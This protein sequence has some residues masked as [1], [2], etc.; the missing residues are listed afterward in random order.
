MT[1][2]R[3]EKLSNSRSAD[4]NQN[5]S[6]LT[7]QT[8]ANAVFTSETV[9][10]K[11]ESSGEMP[12]KQVEETYGDFMKHPV[13]LGTY[14]WTNTSPVTTGF[15]GDIMF[16]FTSGAPTPLKNKLMN[17]RYLKTKLKI[18]VMV[19]GCAYAQGCLLI[20]FDPKLPD[21]G[22]GQLGVTTGIGPVNWQPAQ[23]ARAMLLP[24]LKI[25]PSK[26]QRYEISLECPTQLGV[27]PLLNGNNTAGSYLVYITPLNTLGSGTSIAAKVNLMIYAMLDN[28]TF[29]TLTYTS[30][31]GSK[32]EGTKPS[33]YLSYIGDF[34]DF[35]TGLNIPVISQGT[36]LFTPIATSASRFLSWLGFSRHRELNTPG[37][38]LSKTVN[39]LTTFDGKIEGATLA[40][41][42]ENSLTVNPSEIPLCNFDDQIIS[43]LCSKYTYL[44]Q[45]Q[46]ATTVAADALIFYFPVHPSYAAQT[47]AP[48]ITGS[49]T[50]GVEP[51]PLC[52]L[53]NMF[54]YWRGDITY[55]FEIIASVFHR[56][57]LCFVYFPNISDN[58][59]TT[60]YVNATSTLKAWHVQVS[61]NTEV[62]IT[63]PWSQAD[64]MLITAP[65]QPAALY[66]T[67]PISSVLKPGM[68]GQIACYLCNP[69]ITN[70]STDG[71]WI[72]AYMKCDNIQ[73][74]FPALN[75]MTAAFTF[76]SDSLTSSLTQKYHSSFDPYLQG[77]VFGEPMPSSTKQLASRMNLYANPIETGTG[78][79]T[80]FIEWCYPASM[81]TYPPAIN[82]TSNGTSLVS[83]GLYSTYT[84]F[85]Y[86]AWMYLGHRGSFNYT[87]FPD[88][89]PATSP[90][91]S[92]SIFG[93]RLKYPRMLD[94][95]M[96]SIAYAYYNGLSSLYTDTNATALTIGY[97][98]IQSN[99]N[100]TVPYYYN[101]P[102]KMNFP[103]ESTIASDTSN[104]FTQSGFIIETSQNAPQSTHSPHGALFGGLGDDGMFV[105]FRG[106]PVVLVKVLA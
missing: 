13:M 59:A 89:V 106:V 37:A 79:T 10:S 78:R 45:C 96:N 47:D 28:P 12:V 64:P 81:T 90:L 23:K 31:V 33:Q 94:Q 8:Q 80:N 102:F 51:G 21:I 101:Y 67:F 76:T 68:N 52:Y 85:A 82:N 86:L 54:N 66:S 42:T 88:M 70:G 87:Y 77:R 40:A 91:N 99:I 22:T 19:Q 7:A 74:S 72:N 5:E 61:G 30:S 56:A 16:N 32:E 11:E 104:Q 3:P 57:M 9:Q 83:S 2:P 49:G 95:T 27:Y 58:V 48:A 34:S 17:F 38:Y 25:D 60:G 46:V 98:G 71:I 65:M 36:A 93:V 26:S 97:G 39:S 29:S 103:P 6:A 20:S 24:H 55:K 69:V 84:F 63:I 105:F 14:S 50:I 35:V 15:A 73:F 53:S 92:Y 18:I 4:F 62:E 75:N 100:F 1:F 41:F 43:K 44:G